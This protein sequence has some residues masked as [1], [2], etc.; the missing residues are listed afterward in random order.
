MITNDLLGS[1]H[2]VIFTDIRVCPP[3][4]A[5]ARQRWNFSMPICRFS[6]KF[7]TPLWPRFRSFCSIH[8]LFERSIVEV[9]SHSI[10]KATSWRK[11]FALWWITECDVANT[12]SCLSSN[13]SCSQ[14]IFISQ[15]FAAPINTKLYLNMAWK[16]IKLF[17]E[18]EIVLHT[19]FLFWNTM[20]SQVRTSSWKLQ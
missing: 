14:T 20:E 3:E 13:Y 8:Q 2:S 1:D 9:A 6:E 17:L 19:T 11:L 18:L 5:V 15:N 7:V 16:T 10:P 12:K 4:Q